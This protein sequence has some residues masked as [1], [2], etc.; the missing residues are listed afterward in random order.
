MQTQQIVQASAKVV[1]ITE[2]TAGDVYK[3]FDSSYDD[4]TYYG[5]VNN[6]YNDGTKT[7][8]ESTE[9]CYKY[10]TLEVSRKILQGEKD[11][12]L[13]PS[14]PEELSLDL[15][16]AK[17]G[18]E[19]E[20]EQKKQEIRRLDTEIG[21]IDGLMSGKTL[22]GLKSMSFKELTQEQFNT[23]KEELSL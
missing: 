11:Y 18:K 13:F 10:S 3:R 4:R 22:E 14:S 17:E 2:I 21:D 5:V 19:K 12:I 15:E 7:I 8:I 20:I 16:K 23:K 1:R 9:Y 6:V